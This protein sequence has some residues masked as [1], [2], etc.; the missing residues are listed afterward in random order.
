MHRYCRVAS[1]GKVERGDFYESHVQAIASEPL[2]EIDGFLAACA[3]RLMHRYERQP[4]DATLEI[5]PDYLDIPERTKHF[6]RRLFETDGHYTQEFVTIA[7]ETIG[8]WIEESLVL[9]L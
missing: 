1:V 9:Q 2:H 4:L 6:Y 5:D 7:S 3:L 8:L